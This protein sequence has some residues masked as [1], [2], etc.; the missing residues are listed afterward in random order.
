MPSHVCSSRCEAL[1][2]GETLELLVDV[3]QFVAADLLTL[4]QDL[5][6]FLLQPLEFG[7]QLVV[8]RVQDEDLEAQGRGGDGKVGQGDA[9]RKDWHGYGCGCAVLAF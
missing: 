7:V 6:V 3:V 8:P 5:D 2:G 4:V 9:A 1:A